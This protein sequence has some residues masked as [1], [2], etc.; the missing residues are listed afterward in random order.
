MDQN[1]GSAGFKD[2]VCGMDVDGGSPH[3]QVLDGQ[4]YYFCSVR[5]ME[6]F[7]ADPRHYLEPPK[8]EGFDPGDAGVYTCPMH[9]EVEQDGPGSCPKC[10]MALEPEGVLEG[11]A[12]D[13]DLKAMERRFWISAGLTL[14]LLMIAMVT[15]MGGAFSWLSG[16]FGAWV[17]LGLGSVVILGCGLPFFV[18]GWNS[19]R[20]WNL[21]MYTLISLGAG[22]AWAY[23]VA[24][25]LA[26]GFFPA[27]FHQPDGSLGLYFEA[28][29]VIV[30]LVVLGDVLEQRARRRTSGAIQALLGLQAKTA[31]RLLPGGGEEDVDLRELAV[32]DSLRVRPGEKIPVD[33]VVVEGRSYV[34]EGMVTGEPEPVEKTAG[35]AVT[36]STLNGHGSFVLRAERVGRDTL[37]SR[38]VRMVAEAQRSRAPIQRMADRASTFF[39]PAVVAAATLSFLAWSWFAPEPRLAHALISAVAVLIIACPCALGLATPM[40]VMVGTGRGALAGVL[41]KNAEALELLGKVDTLVVDKTG[42]LTEGKPA[43]VAIE[44]APGVDEADLLAAMA[45]L[46]RGSE[47]P[48][49]LAVLQAAEQRGL[50]R[51]E[52]SDFLAHAGQGVAATVAGRRA[53]AGNAAFMEAQGVDAKGLAPTADAWRAKG[54]TV[55]FTALGGKP[56][57]L[58]AVADPIKKTSA[59]A[60]AAL[61]REGIAVIMLSGDNAVTA[62]AVAGA[63]GIKRFE[64]DLMPAQKAEFIRGLQAQGRKV[65]M[66][67]DGVNDAPALAAADV[68]IAMG[69]GTDIAMHSAGVTLVKGD[70]RGIVKAIRLSRAVMKNIRQNLF[71]AVVYNAAGIPLAAGVL[72]PAFGFLLSPAVAAAA[73]C[74][75]SV[76]VIGNALRLRGLRL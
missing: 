51:W 65:A 67:G 57:G 15:D 17:Q 72:Y 55:L 8:D 69:S 42:T 74:L 4:T 32:G 41:V 33:G 22:T 7:K 29:A 30:T 21:N 18:R 35:C 31:R 36:G 37:L 47:H 45:A 71:F 59:E 52:A 76:S 23:S 40:A 5:C 28:G 6:K 70:L 26:P 53:L 73:M 20:T 38:I 66:A 25:V 48:L 1:H 9:P 19:V 46:E 61:A 63:L 14:P 56:A 2:P 75:S 10:G 54:W 16:I 60:L 68:G 12:D 50:P 39:V 64:A 11:E 24:A 27:A 43:L 49:A 58:L 3:R 62:A 34:D 13:R 44:T